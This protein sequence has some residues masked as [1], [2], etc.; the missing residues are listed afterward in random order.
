MTPR[1]RRERL[2]INRPDVNST[3]GTTFS[4]NSDIMGKV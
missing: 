2:L 4:R 1:I 3:I